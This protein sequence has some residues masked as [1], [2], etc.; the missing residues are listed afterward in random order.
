MKNSAIFICLLAGCLLLAGTALAQPK[1]SLKNTA[2]PVKGA[3]RDCGDFDAYEQPLDVFKNAN[4]SDGE[5]G[6]LTA[7]DIVE[8]GVITP[9]DG[10]VAG[11]RWWG[12]GFDGIAA[13][14]ADDDAAD[15]PFEITF[16]DDTPD[17]GNLIATV[18][19]VVPIIEDTGVPFSTTTISEYSAE[20]DPEVDVTGAT[21]VQ[22]ERETGV[23]RP[24]DQTICIAEPGPVSPVVIPTLGQVGLAA[25]ILSLLGAGGYRLRKKR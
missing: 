20:F 21:W 9:L 5:P 8:A 24:A 23:A 4:L 18:S 17:V 11:M 12:I 15:T 10:E 3:V 22:I 1:T 14:C 16:W 19:G 2:S 13:F 7:E 25:L 6:F